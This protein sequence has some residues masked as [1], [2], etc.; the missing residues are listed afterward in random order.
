MDMKIME[1]VEKNVIVNLQEKDAGQ[2]AKFTHQLS[3]SWATTAIQHM[4]QIC[5]TAEEQI[6]TRHKSSGSSA[7]SWKQ[8]C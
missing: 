3:D 5:A 6:A 8:E 1:Y 7:N 4:I 2:S